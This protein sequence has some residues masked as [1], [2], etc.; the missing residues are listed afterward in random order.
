MK[1]NNQLDLYLDTSIFKKKI[2]KKLD[3]R[4]NI[5][6]STFLILSALTLFKLF[7][8]GLDA[9]EFNIDK[10]FNTE[11][12]LRKAIVDRNNNLLAYNIKTHDLIIRT[13]KVKNL[14][15]LHLKIKINF[16]DI[17]L[18]K[19][20]N[21]YS[22]PFH[23]IKKNLSPSDYNKALSLGEPSIEL[24]RNE[25][26]VYA[27]KNLFSHILGNVDTDQQGVSGLEY[28]MN[29]QLLDKNMKPIKLSLDQNIQ[30]LVREILANGIDT[31]QAIGAS[32]VLIDADNGKILSMVSLPDFNPNNRNMVSN[33]DSYFNKNTKGLYELG[34]VFKTF[35]I[36]NGIEQKI[37]TRDKIYKDLPSQVYCGKF[38]IK[39]Y[40]YSKDKKNLSVNDIL[41]KSSNIGTIRIIQDSGLE[42]YQKFLDKLEIFNSPKI[43]IPETSSSV[44]KRWGKCRT[45]NAG[46][47]HGI[48]TSPLQ[49]S[50]AFAAIINGG[51]LHNLSLLENSKIESGKRII[52]K[53]TSDVMKKI[54]RTNVDKSYEIGGSGRKADIK[55]YNVIGKTGT[56]QKPSKIKKGYSK[57]ILNVFTSAFFI[58]DKSYVLTV[59][60]DEPKGAPKLW[61]HNRREAGWNS[62]YLNGKIIQEIGPILNTLKFKEYTNLIK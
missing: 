26:R 43:E 22:K 62:A 47:G 12:L 50:R 24:S 31:F 46:F 35:V 5:I 1:K 8:L 23:I 60:L 40:R 54:L 61:G 16:K 11:Q 33:K 3:T 18:K 41:V 44:K 39:E 57:E 25:T 27:N 6:I 19:I 21:F 52:S 49:F 9:K 42:S 36:A 34:S 17:D 15:S 53:E 51:R 55:G 59:F 48:N 37:I 45:L 30:F 13:K 58:N 14:N 10:Q 28:F 2:D 38:P 7:L 29:D 20:D 56:A 32:A 4:I